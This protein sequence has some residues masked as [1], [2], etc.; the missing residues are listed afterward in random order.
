MKASSAGHIYVC[1]FGFFC[2]AMSD[3]SPSCLNTMHRGLYHVLFMQLLWG[4]LAFVET[5]FRAVHIWRGLDTF[6]WTTMRSCSRKPNFLG[7][8]EVKCYKNGSVPKKNLSYKPMLCVPNLGFCFCIFRIKRN[9]PKQ[10]KKKE[11]HWVVRVT[12]SNW[13]CF[14]DWLQDMQEHAHKCENG[15]PSS[16]IKD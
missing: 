5:F 3:W 14:L 8:G 12:R 9:H 11:N 16:W 7:L 4:L 10:A 6:L 15:N 1:R 13:Y 2:H